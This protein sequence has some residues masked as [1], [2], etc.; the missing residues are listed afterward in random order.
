[1]IETDRLILR[2]WREAD[3]APFAALNADP[4]V[5]AHFPAPLTRTESDR[6]LDRQAAFIAQDGLGFRAVERRSDGAFIGMV[7][8]TR[9]PAAFGFAPALELGWRLARAFWGYGYA[10]EAALAALRAG[11]DVGAPRVVS[12]TANE[13]VRSQAV[14]ARVGLE[15]RPE[16]DFDHPDLP[17]H[18][19]ERHVVWALERHAFTADPPASGR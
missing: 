14:M 11:F 7:G 5:M 8:V 12:F 2:Q 1:M 18:R 19:L 10:T 3:R 4:Q 6:G 13:N 17:G 9:P 15:R 16:L